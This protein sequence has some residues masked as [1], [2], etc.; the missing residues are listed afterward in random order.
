MKDNLLYYSVGPLLYCPA[1]KKSVANSILQEKFGTGYSLALCLEDTI[2]DR[3]VEEAEQ[4][5]ITSISEIYR[6]RQTQAFYL[7]KIFVRVRNPQQIPRLTKAFGQSIALIAGYIIPKFSLAN[8]A[9]YI[10]AIIQ[11]NEASQ[12]R[13]FLMPI[14]ESPAMLDLNARPSIL[15]GLKDALAQVEELV[16][17][18]RLGGNDFCHLFGFRRHS[19]ESIHRIW[20]I[21]SI[22]SDIVTAYGTEY[23]IS[24]PVWEYYSG[25]NWEQGLISELK[26]DK[27][28]GFTGKTI[29]H[30]NQIDVVNR[31]FMVSRSDFNDAQSILH[32]DADAAS[33][34]SGNPAK[35]RM[36]EYKTHGNWARQTL[37]LAEAYGIREE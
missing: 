28:C 24:G 10:Q 4:D 31:A 26:D 37:F 30:P 20:P 25:Q 6:S 12:K 32:W 17:N 14:Y 15:Y 13:L 5:L 35:E 36:N 3:F 8:A 9:S 2:N 22:F 11:A 19:D 29:I 1:N 34:V 7:P 33:F 23:V 21:A 16:L 27:L 18:I